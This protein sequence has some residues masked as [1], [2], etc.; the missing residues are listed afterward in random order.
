MVATLLLSAS[1]IRLLESTRALYAI[2]CRFF[3]NG[4]MGYMIH[5]AVLVH[6]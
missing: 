6:Y 3:L 5:D 2:R 4:H 1:S